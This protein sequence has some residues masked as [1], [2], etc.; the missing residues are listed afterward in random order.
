MAF[1]SFFDSCNVQD[2]KWVGLDS[3]IL[4]YTEQTGQSDEPFRFKYLKGHHRGCALHS[5]FLYCF[6]VEI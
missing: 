2:K 4:I 5:L 6:L 1:D 3:T